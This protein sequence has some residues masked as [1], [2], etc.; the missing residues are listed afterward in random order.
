VRISLFSRRTDAVHYSE[1][2]LRYAQCRERSFLIGLTIVAFLLRAGWLLRSGTAWALTPDSLEYLSLAKGLEH[3]CGFARWDG[4]ACGIPEAF[5][6]PGYPDFLFIFA[7]H[8]RWILFAQAFI[9]AGMCLTVGMFVRWRW[10]ICAALLATAL[11]AV[12][13]TSIL[14]TKE[15]MTETLFEGLLVAGTFAA[16]IAASNL[17]IS[18]M[19]GVL[20][21]C[22]A[23]SIIGI[24]TLVRPVGLVLV[25]IVVLLFIVPGALTMRRRLIQTLA[26]TMAIA[27][28]VCGWT[29]R[30]AKTAGVW[31]LST[32][33]AFNA[34]A[35]A[36]ATVMAT[37]QERTFDTVEQQF[38]SDIGANQSATMEG[39]PGDSF[40]AMQQL[41]VREPLVEWSMT[42]AAIGIIL[43][44]PL[45]AAEVTFHAFEVLCLRPHEIGLG[46][47]QMLGVNDSKPAGMRRH[48]VSIARWSLD[49]FQIVLLIVMWLGSVR[50]VWLFVQHRSAQSIEVMFY[51]VAAL[52]LLAA[53]SP[54]LGW[55]ID[56]RYRIPAMPFL[57]ILAGIGWFPPNEKRHTSWGNRGRTFAR[58]RAS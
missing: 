44:Y 51:A 13:F 39:I 31:S 56:V 55:M 50:A 43:K 4:S 37:V 24:V 40:G 15:I 9:G 19:R 21:A 1:R 49:V 48:V 46:A 52:V 26:A 22:L 38:A 57:A 23:G 28:I 18:E 34:Y 47:R 53:V 58:Q 30:N 8:I 42:Q 5:R 2:L 33:G 54:F 14:F 11:L 29:V 45:T 3:G 41:I 20:L 10:N 17:A 27:V 12:D 16:L 36:S 35:V 7:S 6:T 32:E 25:P